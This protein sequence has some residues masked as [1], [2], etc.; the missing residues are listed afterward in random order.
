LKVAIASRGKN[1]LNRCDPE[2]TSLLTKHLERFGVEIRWNT[3]VQSIEKEKVDLV[4]IAAGI[5]PNVEIA[6]DAGVEI[7]RCGAIRVDDRMQTNLAGVYA[8]GDCA[9]TY[10]L[11]T[12][13]PEW[14]PLGTTANKMGRVAGANAA[15]HRERFS[16]IVGTSILSVF[17]LGIGIT[18]LSSEQ[19]RG[20]GFSPVE[21][22]IQAR[23]K[24]GYF[25]GRPVTVQ[26]AADRKTR[27]LLGG[28]V[29]GEHDVAGRINV[30]AMALHTGMRVEDFEGSDLA[31]AP[32]F[33]PVWDP[34]LI[35]AQQLMKLLD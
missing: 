30:I 21:T 19:A 5:Q 31:Y 8:A 32:P 13:R 4:L 3:P 23:S 10:H 6:Q 7:G 20:A 17:G 1:A 16:G 11:V 24:P 25:G 27:R 12:A 35:A 33:A 26:L 18:G 34:V 28:Y 9:E 14:V 29:L 2:L 15:G 22:H